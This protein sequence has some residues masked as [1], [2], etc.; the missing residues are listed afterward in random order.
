M[1]GVVALDKGSQ[2]G[3]TSM[4][5]G[6]LGEAMLRPGR[7]PREQVSVAPSRSQPQADPWVVVP[8]EVLSTWGPC[9]AVWANLY[10]VWETGG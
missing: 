6:C 3:H 2:P 10:L 4:S 1:A 8:N 9:L 7:H 5:P